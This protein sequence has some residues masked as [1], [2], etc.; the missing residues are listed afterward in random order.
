MIDWEGT[1]NP[2]RTP[3]DV[4]C[5]T[6]LVARGPRGAWLQVMLDHPRV[7]EVVLEKMTAGGCY[8]PF[9]DHEGVLRKMLDDMT[10]YAVIKDTIDLCDA[11]G[12]A[13]PYP[14]LYEALWNIF[15][16]IEDENA[17]LTKGWLHRSR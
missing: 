12:A 3:L 7:R 10:G 2:Y 17:R 1:P 13:K 9:R 8:E 14:R 16:W 4:K 11:L 6:D 5:E 15:Q